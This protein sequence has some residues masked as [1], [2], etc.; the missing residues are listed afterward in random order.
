LQFGICFQ[1]QEPPSRLR[2]Q[3]FAEGAN[4]SVESWSSIHRFHAEVIRLRGQG[5]KADLRNGNENAPCRSAVN[6][7]RNLTAEDTVP[8]IRKTE[9]NQTAT[10]RTSEEVGACDE[11][12]W[13]SRI[14]T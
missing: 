5:A 12:S 7:R 13:G 8:T 4:K 14:R 1:G 6:R 9:A 11:K 3:A 10:W 2:G